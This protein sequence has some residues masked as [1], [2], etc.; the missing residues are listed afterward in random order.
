MK[1]SE[2]LNLLESELAELPESEIKK[3][4]TYYSE[5]IDDRIED[6]ESESDAV[7]SLGSI[8]E[9]SKSVISQTPLS[10]KVG[11]P[12]KKKVRLNISVLILL[13]LGSPIWLSILLALFSVIISL[14]A[15]I[16]SIIIAMYSVV[17]ALLVGGA[18]AVLGSP[19]IMYTNIHTGIA[20]IGAGFIMFGLGIFSAYGT[21]ILSKLII[22]F[23]YFIVDKIKYA[24]IKVRSAKSSKQMEGDLYVQKL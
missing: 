17:A 12:A 20:L 16:V 9:I 7:A 11:E 5:M 24:I 4:L 8:D 13:I 1:K 18:A 10:V 6:G 15:A 3:S 19:I 21:V 2:F 14:Y 23:T 22:K